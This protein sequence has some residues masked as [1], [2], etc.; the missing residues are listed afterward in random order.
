M[1][2]LALEYTH[3]RGVWQGRGSHGPW[4]QWEACW[5]APSSSL[6]RI[7]RSTMR[8]A[9]F[10]LGNML[11]IPNAH[12]HT[13]PYHAHANYLMLSH[14]HTELILSHTQGTP[15]LKGLLACMKPRVSNVQC[16]KHY[17]APSPP[18][19]SYLCPFPW[20]LH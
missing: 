20:L 13:E 15:V 16:I 18:Q 2:T 19:R 5:L 14:A 12:A 1:H 8:C 10:A 9:D 6:S 3:R 11:H 7:D 4:Q 17:P